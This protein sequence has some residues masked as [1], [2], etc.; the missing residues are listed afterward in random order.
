MVTWHKNALMGC[1]QLTQCGKK[2]NANSFLSIQQWRSKDLWT[3][4]KTVPSNCT[5]IKFF[6][7][8]WVRSFVPSLLP[9]KVSPKKGLIFNHFVQNS[10][11]FGVGRRFQHTFDAHWEFLFVV[12][13]LARCFWIIWLLSFKKP[14]HWGILSNFPFFISHLKKPGRKMAWSLRLA[15]GCFGSL[16]Y[17]LISWLLCWCM[18]YL[19]FFNS[20]CGVYSSHS[21][22]TRWGTRNL[23]Y[24][25][26][27]H[28]FLL[29]ITN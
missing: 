6:Y 1:K 26:V 11:L 22:A 8:L 3:A 4:G 17:F 23:I 16:F 13:I 12:C 14:A 5:I 2:K 24:V 9:S 25:L 27:F 19:I 20:P 10:K 18:W 21:L 28:D 7:R 29:T 15:T